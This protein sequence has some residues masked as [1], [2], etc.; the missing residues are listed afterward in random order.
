MFP[1]S[2]VQNF[3][4]LTAGKEKSVAER[5]S[6]PHLMGSRPPHANSRAAQTTQAWAASSRQPQQ[7][8]EAASQG[9]VALQRPEQG[10]TQGCACLERAPRRQLSTVL[11]PQGMA[12]FPT[13]W[14]AAVPVHRTVGCAGM[15]HAHQRGFWMP[16]P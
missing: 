16:P 8:G 11:A 4:H 9:R 15:G 13:P 3:S 2:H 7:W 6:L 1:D 12:S 10:S 5:T 14:L